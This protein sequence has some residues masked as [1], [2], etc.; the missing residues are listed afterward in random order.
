[1]EAA[2][3][4]TVHGAARLTYVSSNCNL[5][6]HAYDTG[7]RDLKHQDFVDSA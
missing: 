5:D 4:S 2:T 7:N 6:P 3:E 1:M